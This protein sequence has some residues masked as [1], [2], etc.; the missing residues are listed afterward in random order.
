MILSEPDILMA[1][2][3][4]AHGIRGE[5]R[6]KSFAADPL[7]L[8]DYGPLRTKDGRVF[9][10]ETIR[11]AK[12][13]VIV[14]FAEVADRNQAETLAGTELFV[15]REALPDDLEEEEFYHADLVGLDVCLAVMDVLWQEFREPR[16]V[17]SPLLR[18]KVV[19]VLERDPELSILLA[20]EAIDVATDGAELPIESVAALRQAIHSSPIVHRERMA[21]DSFVWVGLSRDG[22]QL[23]AAGEETGI[24]RL[25]DTET[26]EMIWE[27]HCG[28]LSPPGVPPTSTGLP[29]LKTM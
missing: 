12:G 3:G 4:A 21:D 17:A 15:A 19:R 13:A 27:F 1:V 24:A 23:L 20:L 14:G 8:G 9:T 11:P 26:W 7:A 28:W 16:Y 25:I 2:I 10:V 18:R 6:V 22:S 5:L 29:S